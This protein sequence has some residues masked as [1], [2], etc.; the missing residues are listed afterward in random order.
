MEFA[1]EILNIP[2]NAESTFHP[3]T[4]RFHLT[5]STILRYW[6]V[7]KCRLVTSECLCSF[8]TPRRGE[9]RRFVH[10]P[11]KKLFRADVRFY[12]RG[13]RCAAFGDSLHCF[14]YARICSLSNLQFIDNRSDYGNSHNAVIFADK[15]RGKKFFSRLRE[16]NAERSRYA[17]V[18]KRSVL[19]KECHTF[20]FAFNAS[21]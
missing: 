2:A 20:Y 6:R 13:Q 3:L 21:G 17:K 8:D 14:V 9:A 12:P 4:I 16:R 19:M 18:I 7:R 11:L 5:A 1:C 10:C 15:T